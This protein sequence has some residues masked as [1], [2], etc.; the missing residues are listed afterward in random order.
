M[1]HLR[2]FAPVCLAGIFVSTACP[3]LDLTPYF[4]TRSTKTWSERIPYFIDGQTKYTLGLTR[5]MNVFDENGAARFFFDAAEGGSLLIK[6]SPLS[7]AS[8]T[9]DNIE[10]YHKH[11][12]GI[13][14]EGAQEVELQKDRPLSLSLPGKQSL[15]MTYAYKLP[16]RRFIQGISFVNFSDTQQIILV[17]TSPAEMFEQTVALS[18]KVLQ[19]WRT[20]GKEEDLSGVP[21]N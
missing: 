6:T 19:S 17:V 21:V 20:V 10:V 8:V 12:L 1:L 11:A 4:V 18:T 7:P 3:A 9:F 14:P 2:S 13:L 5:G 16:G 15:G